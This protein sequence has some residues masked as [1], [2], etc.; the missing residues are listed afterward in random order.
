GRELRSLNSREGVWLIGTGTSNLPRPPA[1]DLTRE[2][3]HEHAEA[4]RLRYR[5]SGLPGHGRRGPGRGGVV[6]RRPGPYSRGEP[7][8]P[9]HGAIA[10]NGRFRGEVVPARAAREP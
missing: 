10:R 8:A 6:R 2:E 7:G 9:A 5:H 4:D 3:I 1:A